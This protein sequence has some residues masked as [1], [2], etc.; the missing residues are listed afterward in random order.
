VNDSEV[1]VAVAAIDYF[2]LQYVNISEI[3]NG[4]VI[5][6]YPLDNHSNVTTEGIFIIIII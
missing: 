5:S 4:K 6:S 3:E 2:D 1:K